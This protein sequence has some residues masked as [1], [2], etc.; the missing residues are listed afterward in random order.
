MTQPDPCA[1]T[2]ALECER[3]AD[4]IDVMADER[5]AQGS[6]AAQFQAGGMREAAE[7]VRSQSPVEGS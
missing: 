6:K 2:L 7:Y 3:M 1:E 4:A 5:H